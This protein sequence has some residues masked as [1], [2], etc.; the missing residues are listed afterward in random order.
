M[1]GVMP[2]LAILLVMVLAGTCVAGQ[3][4]KVAM[5]AADRDFFEAKVRP[6]LVQRC[7][8][9]HSAAA[10]KLRGGL[11]LDS[12]AG[13][14]KGGVSGAVI[15]TARPE[16]SLLLRVVRQEPEVPK[17]PP[18]GALPERDIATLAEWARRGAPMP[19]STAAARAMTIE[20]G[21]RFWSVRPLVEQRLPAV[22]SAD[23]PRTRTDV[24]LLG[25]LESHALVPSPAADRRTLVRRLFFDLIG[26]PPS[27]EEVE[28]F[29]TDSDPLAYERL[30]DRLL[31]SPQHG[32]RWGRY[33]LDL[34][35]YADV[36]EQWSDC[37]GAPWLYR[38]WV[39]RA[40]QTDLPYDQFM[41]RQIAADLL[42]GTSPADH[43][44]LGFLGLSP[45][46]WKELKLAPDVIRTVV[47]EEWEE[48]IATF[49]A[50]FLGLTVACARCHDHKYDPITTQDYYALAGVF[51][52]LR[53]VDR[54]PLPEAEA[55]RVSQ[56][57]DHVR[58]LEA[59][60]AALRMEKKPAADRDQQVAAA[61][62]EASRW[63]QTA[64]YDM[65]AVP[66][67]A[68]AALVVLPDG[69]HRTK[70]D[71]RPGTAQDVAVQP[72]GN[73][74]AP[75][76]VV[77]RRFLA[78]LSPGDPTPFR[79]GSGR[80]ELAQALAR[81]GSPLAARVIVNRVWKHHFGSGLVETPSDFGSQGARPSHPELLDDLAARLVASGWSLRWLHREIVLS[82]AYRQ[83]SA[84][85]PAKQVAD[86]DNR[87]LWR[88]NRRRLEVEA[89]RDAMLAVTGRLDRTVGGPSRD[90]GEPGNVRRTLYGTVRRREI[91]DLLRLYDFPDP[92][93][94]A[95]ARIP[96]TT[97]LQQL[98]VLN[99][100]FMQQQAE[101]LTRRVA[102]EA[103]GS[104]EDRIRSAYALLF[105]RPPHEKEL[106]LG[107][108]FLGEGKPDEMWP[109]YA[110][111]LLASNEFLFVD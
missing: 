97:P 93:T 86:P 104:Q 9:C 16:T 28:A 82:A 40:I 99:S 84:H 1:G 73:P 76:P 34:A 39:V 107:L 108:A 92:I 17:M 88:M 57:Q 74:T 60:I 78:V 85:D 23:W 18:S 111:A 43:A 109:A 4:A 22:K 96:T 31:A 32:E 101:A 29:V 102:R 3:P 105:G 24:F 2:R 59:R 100:P 49:S 64:H 110:Q 46:Y 41:Q 95:P 77:P 51:A 6:I 62:A 50:T 13:V 26:L 8:G 55:E 11:R 63:R 35:R 71:W 38:D 89:W 98:F 56:A 7:F 21:R 53:Q 47:A 30:V 68:D 12:P 36:T 91:S 48:R 45:T 15:D 87:W 52:S 61:Q 19:E 70:L 20:E 94:H 65:P 58:A 5:S 67:V 33:W 10:R 14:R 80:L 42:P 75:G 103:P 83:A 72:R 106:R 54:L 66:A 79:S 37:K 81:D 25:A 27:R 90:L 69:A 44:A